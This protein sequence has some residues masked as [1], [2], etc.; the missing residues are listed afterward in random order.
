MSVYPSDLHYLD[1]VEQ[2]DL[3]RKFADGTLAP[4]QRQSLGQFMTPAPIAR[5]MASLF[6]DLSEAVSLLDP[7]ADVGSLTSAVVD[8]AIHPAL[9]RSLIDFCA[10][11]YHQ[12]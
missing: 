3:R 6:T 12:S 4:A 8:R 7:G 9:C 5:F 1:L 2:V 11:W 10:V